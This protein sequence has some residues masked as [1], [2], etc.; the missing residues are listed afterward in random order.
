MMVVCSFSA[1]VRTA[2]F[3]VVVALVAGVSLAGPST[4]PSTPGQGPAVS[5]STREPVEH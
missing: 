3:L 1:L 2:L 4:P 5:M